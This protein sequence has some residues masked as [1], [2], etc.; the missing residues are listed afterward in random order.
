MFTQELLP[1]LFLSLSFKSIL[2][3]QF[4]NNGAFSFLN[5]GSLKYVEIVGAKE[6]TSVHSPNDLYLLKE[7]KKD[8]HLL[9]SLG[10]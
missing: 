9:I 7:K 5:I 2:L 4:C 10:I 3:F 8:Q 6:S 1:G